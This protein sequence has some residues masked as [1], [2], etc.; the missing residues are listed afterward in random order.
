MPN[1]DVLFYYDIKKIKTFLM[2][3]FL[4]NSYN[5]LYFIIVFRHYYNPQH[6][7]YIRQPV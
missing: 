4:V 1:I 7:F 6:I 5:M 3:C 2:L